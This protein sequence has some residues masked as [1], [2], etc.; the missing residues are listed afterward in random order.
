[1]K[2]EPKTLTDNAQEKLSVSS[3][4]ERIAITHENKDFKFPRTIILNQEEATKL[5][6]Y[7]TEWIFQGI[8]SRHI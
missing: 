8:V 4:E 2:M 1:M 5:R 3:D 6:D 7:I